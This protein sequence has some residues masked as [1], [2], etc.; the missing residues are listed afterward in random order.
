MSKSTPIARLP[1]NMPGG[2]DS[3]QMTGI[4]EQFSPDPQ[5]MNNPGGDPMGMPP[6]MD[7]TRAMMAAQHDAQRQNEND[8]FQQRQFVP[9]VPTDHNPFSGEN[10]QSPPQPMPPA[11]Q[12]APDQQQQRMM[13]EQQQRMMYEQQQQQPIPPPLPEIEQ[14]EYDNVGLLSYFMY[15]IKPALV[16]FFLLVLVQLEGV[17]TAFRKAVT[18]LRIPESGIYTGAKVLS[19][20][21]GAVVF[22]LVLRNL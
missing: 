12:Y 8:Q 20:L 17:Q 14:E 5:A 9:Q 18:M 2:G 7:R 22:L 15:N 11:G 16:V 3:V 6:D 10:Q 1:R 4:R 21:I 19:S 13:Y